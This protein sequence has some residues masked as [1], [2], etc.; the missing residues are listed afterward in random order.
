MS[1]TL[2]LFAAGALH[3]FTHKR[4]RKRDRLERGKQTGHALSVLGSG[5][6]AYL[7]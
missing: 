2:V 3:H 5:L 6:N 4:K 1:V 7:D